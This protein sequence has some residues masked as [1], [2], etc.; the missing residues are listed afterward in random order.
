VASP[1]RAAAEEYE[2]AVAAWEDFS[3]CLGR[4]AGFPD[5]EAAKKAW[6][7]AENRARGAAAVRRAA[8]HETAAVAEIEKALGALAG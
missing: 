8:E 2:A 6:A 1:L 3:R 5:L 7:T 4:L